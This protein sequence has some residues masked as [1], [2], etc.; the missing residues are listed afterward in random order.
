MHPRS[1]K[2]LDDIRQSCA[3]IL[4]HTEGASLDDYLS[5][6]LVR[7]AVERSLTIVGEALVRLRRV[8]PETAAQIT[9]V[10][11]IIGLRNR[12]AHGYDDVIDDTLVWKAVR[13]SIPILHAEAARLLPEFEP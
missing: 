9:N 1:P 11:Q 5:D 13:D 4:E 2:W 12:L 7:H 6:P 3:F 10:H 8:D